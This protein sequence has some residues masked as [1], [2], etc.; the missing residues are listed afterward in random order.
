MRITALGKTRL[1]KVFVDLNHV[2]VL[3]SAA[4]VAVGSENSHD[5]SLNK[6]K[7]FSIYPFYLYSL[8]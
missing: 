2:Q 6:V 5:F 8:N 1:G 3:V 7:C 4:S